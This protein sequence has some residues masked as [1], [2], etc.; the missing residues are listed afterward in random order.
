M[1]W[2]KKFFFVLC[3]LYDTYSEMYCKIVRIFRLQFCILDWVL[4]GNISCMNLLF[5]MI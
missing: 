5:A 1:V 3:I 4:A 2:V